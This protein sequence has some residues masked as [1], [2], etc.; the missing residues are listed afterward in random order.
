[1]DINREGY[2]LKGV[3]NNKHTHAYPPPER[4]GRHKNIAQFPILRVIGKLCGKYI[5]YN[6]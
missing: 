6:G 4:P 3:L 1:M 2:R 5:L